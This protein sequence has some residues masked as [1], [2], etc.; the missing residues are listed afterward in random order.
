MANVA[1]D[2]DH[3]RDTV[4]TVDKEGK[5]VW[6]YPKKPVGKYFNARKLV[7]YGLLTILFA[8][9]FL[10]INGLPVLMLNFPARKFII[11]GQIFW[12]QD[13]FILLLAFLT[14]V[15]F[16][17]LFTVV[18]GRVFCGWVC[19]QTIFMEM[20]FRR[21]EYFIEGDYNKQKALNKA[22]W[23]REKILKKGTK[24]TIFL[25]ISF[26]I[27]NLFLAYIIGIDELKAIVLDSPLNHLAGLGTLLVFAGMFYWVYASFR[28]Q[29][30]T[31]V[32]PY[33]RLQGV[34]MDKKTTVIAYDFVRGEPREKQRKGQ[35]RTAGDCIDCN[36]CV[37]VCPT[38]IDIRNGTQLE[39]IN[40]TA[41]IDACNNIMDLINKPQGLIRYDSMEGIEKGE[42]WKLTSRIKG[43]TA[44]LLVL[45]GILITLLVTRNNVDATIL[46]TPGMLFQ[47]SDKGNIINL[48]NISVIN[49][50]NEEMPITLKL[51]E[52]A[53]GNIQ[54][55]K[56]NLVLPKQGITEG[57][58]LAE[59][60]LQYLKGINSEI[61]I[62][63]YSQGKLIAVEKTK[64][65]GPAK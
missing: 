28:E 60:P 41:C 24:H 15:V 35:E 6:L 3:F 26:L 53:Q 1:T 58:F 20:V 57:V 42:K 45:M 65:M 61:E 10:K 47:K 8:V 9:P 22:P 14:L 43:Y 5:R 13:F 40:C 34:M 29:V 19:P 12:P 63:V 50:T 23:T 37:Q 48:Y 16:I 59:I 2:F 31:I 30:C 38:G 21:I 39:C 32:C 51:M 36:Q 33:G 52:P 27:A 4:S 55:V 18:Y 7:S 64:F 49:K 54:V 44:V 11:F 46:R 17:I 25:A 56:N 62:G